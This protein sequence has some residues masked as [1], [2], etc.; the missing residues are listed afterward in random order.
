MRVEEREV[1]TTYLK[2]RVSFGA[3][4][5]QRGRRRRPLTGSITRPLAAWFSMAGAL[6]L[7]AVLS[8]ACSATAES[9]VPLMWAVLG[10]L[11]VGTLL[12]GVGL[13]RRLRAAEAN[14]SRARTKWRA[15]AA[16]A[17][18]CQAELDDLRKRQEENLAAAVKELLAELQQQ[19]RELDQED[20]WWKRDGQCGDEP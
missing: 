7:S 1:M 14:A 12:F 5:S 6:G 11:L 3:S 18:R 19:G 15:A 13:C 10:A 4:R 17:A 2:T 9:L 20:N 16:K 8:A